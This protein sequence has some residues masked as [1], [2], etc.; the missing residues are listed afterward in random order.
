MTDFGT[1]FTLRGGLTGQLI[2]G[3]DLLAE[4]LSRRIR[5]PRGSCFYD[6]EYGTSLQDFLGEG[7]QD[8]GEGVC[9]VLEAEI[10]D[11]P[12]VLSAVLTPVSATLRTLSIRADVQTVAGPLAL[13]INADAA[14]QILTPQIEVIPY[15]TG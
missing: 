7:I 14:G 2:S 15:G 3:I 12:R 9:A 13:V 11:D 8:G 1:D 6:P 10:E 5:S 4:S